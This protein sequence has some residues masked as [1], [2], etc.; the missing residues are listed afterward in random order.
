MSKI[1]VMALVVAVVA[2]GQD[3]P[4]QQAPQRT[5]APGSARYEVVEAGNVAIRLNRYTGE[6]ARR[7]DDRAGTRWEPVEVPGRPVAGAVPRFQI[8]LREN[9]VGMYLLDTETGQTW[10]SVQSAPANA[11]A[12]FQWKAFAE[13]P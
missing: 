3:R 1:F 6:T 12:Y 7:I 2:S 5:Q 4:L 10:V 13:L 11:R 8:V 9:A